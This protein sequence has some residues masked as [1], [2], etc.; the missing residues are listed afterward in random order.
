MLLECTLHS[1]VA[2]SSRTNTLLQLNVYYT[3]DAIGRR[4]LVQLCYSVYV[5]V[6]CL[7]DKKKNQVMATIVGT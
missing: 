3:P 5:H 7:R 6:F 2:R 1:V 4:E